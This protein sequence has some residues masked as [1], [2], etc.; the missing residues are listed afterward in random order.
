[1]DRF[2]ASR[3]ADD[4]VAFGPSIPLSFA[5]LLRHAGTVA[6]ALPDPSPGSH[7]A[8]AFGRDRGACIAALLGAWARGHAVALPADAR[9]QSVAPVLE[10]AEVVAFVHD[11]GVGRGIDVPRLLA[12]P[13]A[14]GQALAELPLPGG[15][16]AFASEPSGSTAAVRFTGDML[17]AQID[18]LIRQVAL[19]Q[20]V[21]VI[22]SGTPTFL[23]GLLLGALAPLRL[24]GAF[25]VDTP[26]GPA[27]TAALVRA[28]RAQVLVSA[29]FQLRELARLSAGELA[30]LALVVVAGG[31]LDDRTLLALRHRHGLVVRAVPSPGVDVAAPAEAALTAALL[32]IDGVLDAATALAGDAAGD[33]T[34]LLAAVA[35]PG[36]ADEVLVA[37]LGALH[38]AN[39]PPLLRRLDVLPRDPNGGLSRSMLFSLLGCRA[40][41]TPQCRT[42][43]W[44]HD[45]AQAAATS[46]HRFTT[47]LPA[48]FFAFAGH[49]PS[50]PVLA[51]AVQL[52]ELVLPCLRRVRPDARELTG[53][54]DL[55]FLARIAPGDEVE[56]ALCSLPAGDAVLFVISRGTTRCSSGRLSFRCDDVEH[57]P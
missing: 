50:Y 28:H 27:A 47:R 12:V 26:V 22:T 21:R 36:V 40:D 43:T 23:P 6:A 25:G 53:V 45:A 57:T 17:A 42:L 39:T 18:A 7:V 51:G 44:Q 4:P 19:P 37:R 33:A 24:G 29:P 16:A 9:R 8:F 32:G 15:L 48:E 30:P 52:Q 34:R 11:T 14:A 49:F 54:V 41:G 56:V 38:P 5:A 10:R 31:N 20:A 1:V 35:A 3:R 13:D 2:F 55:K 46:C